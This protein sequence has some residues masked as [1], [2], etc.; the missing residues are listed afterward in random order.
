MSSNTN[1][2][3][4]GESRGSVSSW[5][6]GAS[7]TGLERWAMEPSSNPPT[8]PHPPLRKEAMNTFHSRLSWVCLPRPPPDSGLFP[9]SQGLRALV[10]G[11]GEGFPEAEPA[12]DT[13]LSPL[14]PPGEEYR[15]LL[16]YPETTAQILVQALNPLDYRK[17][18]T[19]PMYWR[20]LKV[21]KVR[22]GPWGQAPDLVT[23]QDSGPSAFS[24]AVK[25]GAEWGTLLRT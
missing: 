6:G 13:C 22:G 8:P 9:S 23:A 25:S 5:G 14:A 2:Y 12:T 3:D 18:R 1:S 10:G 17:W 24:R 19:K 11:K 4:Y 21:F 16:L 15:P 20:V 7:W